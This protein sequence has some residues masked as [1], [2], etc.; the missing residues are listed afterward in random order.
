MQMKP[1]GSNIAITTG[2]S[3]PAP[4]RDRWPSIDAN[5]TKRYQHFYHNRTD[6]GAAECPTIEMQ[7]QPK[8]TKLAITAGARTPAPARADERGEARGAPC[9]SKPS[10]CRRRCGEPLATNHFTR[11]YN[12]KSVRTNNVAAGEAVIQRRCSSVI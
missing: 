5:E 10:T 9:S 6:E 3:T 2:A 12:N 1:K 4:T 7:T 8:G 11:D